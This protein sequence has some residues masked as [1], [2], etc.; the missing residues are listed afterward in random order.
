METAT[1]TLQHSGSKTHRGIFWGGLVGGALDILAA[2]VLLGLRGVSPIQVLQS[3]SSGL[4][5]MEAYDGGIPIALLG[6]GL[7]FLIAT[8]A[9]T[10]YHFASLRISILVQ[11][12]VIC[13]LLF[14]VAVY[15]FMNFIVLP[16]SAFPHKLSYTFWPFL[17]GMS[18]IMF[19]VGLPISL[20]NKHFSR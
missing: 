16:A 13:G 14:G 7:H 15:L 6:L 5:G 11:H 4:L 17:R 19:C 10:V 1:I 8:T 18:V 9:A 2:F 12:A 20:I 3:I